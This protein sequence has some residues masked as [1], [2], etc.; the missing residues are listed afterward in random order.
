MRKAMQANSA[1]A[2]CGRFALALAGVVGLAVSGCMPGEQLPVE[3][4]EQLLQTDESSERSLA[5]SDADVPVDDDG[6]DAWWLVSDQPWIKMVDLPWQYAEVQYRQG[7]SIGYSL[8]TVSRSDIAEFNQLRVRREDIIDRDFSGNPIPPRRIVYEAYETPYG[9]LNSYR[10]EATASGELE[11]EVEGR[12]VFHQLELSRR[13]REGKAR[14]LTLELPK[15]SWGPLGV[16]AILMREPMQTGEVRRARIHIPQLAEFV[17][18]RLTAKGLDLTTVASGRVQELLLV[19]ATIGQPDAGVMSHIWVDQA[20]VIQKTMTLSGESMLKL[21]VDVEIVQR[22][23]DQGRFARAVHGRYQLAESSEK[24]PETDQLKLRVFSLDRDP[25]ASFLRNARQQVRSLSASTCEVI[26]G[27][28]VA[29]GLPAE[30]SDPPTEDHL[31]STVLIPASHPLVARLAVELIGQVDELSPRE[32]AELLRSELQRIWQLQP[33]SDE[34]RS[35]LECA[36]N[37]AG[38][39]IEC[40]CLLAALLRQQ[41]I[42]AQL[43]GGLLIDPADSSAGFHVWTQAWIDH[44]WVELDATI[45]A[46]VGTRHLAMTNTVAAGENLYQPWLPMLQAIEDISEISLQVER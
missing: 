15:G 34:I 25:Y 28:G 40:A 16:Q 41:Q 36:R 8:L 9:E 7:V 17:P 4:R 12:A 5:N 3:V 29:D 21:R 14:R 46:P 27:A 30:S 26:L 24:L 13:E 35:T 19:E 33:R 45:A 31:S 44:R 1:G 22:L 2:F 32:R 23:V 43:V 42:P 6:G 18:V 38:G 20:G 37:R 10:L 39:N 11:L